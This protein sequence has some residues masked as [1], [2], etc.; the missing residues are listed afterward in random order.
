M[1]RPRLPARAPRARRSPRVALLALALALVTGPACAHGPSKK[2]RDAAEIHYQ[3]GAEALRSGRREEA[4]RELDEA[5]AKDPQHAAAH[6]GRG[7]VLQLHERNPEAEEAYRRALAI[8]PRLP[9]AHNALGQLLAQTGRLEAALPE[10][11]AALAEITYQQAFLARCNKGQ[12][13]A[14]LGRAAEGVVELRACLA[15]APRFCR[16]HRELGRVELEQGHTRE[17]LAAFQ[18]YGE[19]CGN[20][21][22]PWF[23][24][25]LLHLKLG[26][27]DKARDAFERCAAMPEGPVVA[28]CRGKAE[29]LR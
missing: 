14:A 19:L 28:E 23:Q 17:A 12:A 2:D 29:A 11:D 25:G 18:R 9:D 22:D 20:E 13:L 1:K 15:Q 21:P 10:F 8:N 7:I 5:V 3:L 27:S 6:L 16:G 26:D 4:M 24:L